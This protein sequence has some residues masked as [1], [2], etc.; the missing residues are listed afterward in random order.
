[1]QQKVNKPKAKMPSL[2]QRV[3]ASR[4]GSS[5]ETFNAARIMARALA[6]ATPDDQRIHLASAFCHRLVAAWWQV[7]TGGDK[8][9]PLRSLLQALP[10]LD[11]LPEP[12]GRVG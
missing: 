3:D 12:V 7:L 8:S 11:Q 10:D 4:A 1:M 2:K 9:L 5:T 6:E